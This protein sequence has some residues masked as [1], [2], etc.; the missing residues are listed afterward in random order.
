[1]SHLPRSGLVLAA[2]SAAA[3]ALPAVA[4]ANATQQSMMMDDDQ[5][6]YRGDQARDQ[7]LAKMA[8]LGV[9][10]IRV[11]VLWKV[12]ADKARSTKA[13]DR[14]FRRLGATNPR[15]YPKLNWERY[16]RLVRAAGARGIGVYFDVT[17]P[18]PRWAHE[19]APR[20]HRR[21]QGTWKPRA[22][23]FGQFVQAVGERYSGT[24]RDENDG[25]Q[26]LPRVSFWAIGNEPNQGGWLTPQ[27][28]GGKPASPALYRRLFL[29][30]HRGLARSGHGNDTILIGETAPLGSAQRT[31]RSPMRPLAFIRSLFCVAKG[32]AALHGA[33]A[34]GC[35]GFPLPATAY[36]HHPYAKK[37]A[38]TQRYPYPDGVSMANIGDIPALLDQIAAKTGRVKSGL[39]VVASE[40]GYE[41][42]P[43][44]PFQGVAL[45]TQAQWNMLGDLLAY[46]QPRVVA[47]TQFLLRDAGPLT[48]HKKGSKAYWF[49]YQSGLYFANGQPKPAAYAYLFPFVATGSSEWGQ[50][51][52]RPNGSVGDA[53][54]LQWR[55]AGG[56]FADVGAPVPVTSPLG[57]FEAAVAPPGPGFMRAVWTADTTIASPEA[58]VG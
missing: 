53:V 40:F 4:S 54:Q 44:D 21:D 3:L 57:Y 10:R 9:D 20:A 48:S 6:L 39:D 7:A 14:T 2:L 56:A 51:R 23:A 31:T 33:A 19:T 43:P 32:A 11:T 18:G 15:A 47:N 49:T 30:G 41:S 58:A 27:W 1:M 17:F 5:L 36:A 25:R 26:A 42:N 8:A 22:G 35:A 46:R 45:A 34:R 12:V 16:D 50:M 37:A 24:Y 28:S 52:F 29:A 38:P 55:P 13:R